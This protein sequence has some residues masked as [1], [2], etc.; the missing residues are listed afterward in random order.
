MHTVGLAL[1]FETK[2]Y[3]LYL[4]TAPGLFIFVWEFKQGSNYVVFVI[5]VQMILVNVLYGLRFEFFHSLPEV[6][7]FKSVFL[8]TCRHSISCLKAMVCGFL[9]FRKTEV[10][11]F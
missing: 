1:T 6:F 9:V 5:Q 10:L 3:V 4:K 8:M 2:V 11:F 7:P